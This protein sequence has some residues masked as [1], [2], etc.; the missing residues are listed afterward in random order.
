[1]LNKIK[2]DENYLYQFINVLNDIEI[3]LKNKKTRKSKKST[4]KSKIKTVSKFSRI[5]EPS[6]PKFYHQ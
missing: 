5:V 3:I 1:M 2:S 4:I 6:L